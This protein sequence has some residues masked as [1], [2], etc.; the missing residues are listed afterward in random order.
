MARNF[1]DWLAG[2]LEYTKASESPLQFHF[3]TGVSVIAGALRGKVWR[4]EMTFRW[5]PNLYTILVGPPGIAQKSTSM[6]LGMSLLE[7]IDG[8]HFGPSSATWQSLTQTMQ[9]AGEEINY[10]DDVGNNASFTISCVTLAISELGTFMKLASEGFADVLIDMW[11]GQI[12]KRNWTHATVASS[13]ASIANPWLNMIG[14]TTP[15]WLRDN[16]PESMIGGGLTSRIVFVYGSRKRHLVAYPSQSYQKGEFHDL[17]Q[18]LIEDLNYIAIMRGPL[19]MTPEAISWGQKWYEDLWSYRPPHLSNERYDAYIARKQVFLHKL[20]M[21]VAAAKSN[22][23]VLTQAHLE[24]ANGLLA[25]IE[26][27]MGR[28]F[29]SIGFTPQAAHV[30][31]ITRVLKTYKKLNVNDL[32]YF[33]RQQISYKD[34]KEALESGFKSG[35]LTQLVAG[36]VAH[37]TLTD[38]DEEE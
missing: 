14:C 15:S 19:D 4:D 29:Q 20:A 37:I 31:S 22:E 6:K 28:V 12:Q 17:R 25:V 13:Q 10:L 36:G 11:D 21:I 18:R 7:E 5:T 9:N 8:V 33:V 2:Y 16:Y 23:M 26:K 30:D 34:Y 24:Q 1:P 35:V 3:W 38:F 27:N 32:Y